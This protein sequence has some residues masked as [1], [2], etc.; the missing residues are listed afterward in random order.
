MYCRVWAGSSAP[1]WQACCTRACRPGKAGSAT[2]AR[3][4]GW[5]ARH[6]LKT[7]FASAAVSANPTSACNAVR[8][9]F[10]A[11]STTS[12][13]ARVFNPRKKLR[14][15]AAGS[16][17]APLVTPMPNPAAMAQTISAASSWVFTSCATATP[18]ASHSPSQARSIVVLPAP[19]SPL[20]TRNGN[21]CEN[22]CRIVDRMLRCCSLS[23][24]KAGSGLSRNGGP[25]MPKYR[26][27]M[28]G[29]AKRLIWPLSV[30]EIAE[31]T[32]H[33]RCNTQDQ[34]TR[35]LLAW[36][37]QTLVAHPVSATTTSI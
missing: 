28:V 15:L 29:L 33:R 26:S 12:S 7:A 5:P 16:A 18:A 25:V 10:C 14:R 21:V 32:R 34:S 13:A 35:G 17:F 23:K 24:R 20:T 30:R 1:R 31:Q 3:S 8:L 27:Y 22:T 36:R 11:S 2:C 4:S 9:R 37:P 19:I 6:I